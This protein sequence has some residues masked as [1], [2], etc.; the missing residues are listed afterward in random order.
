MAAYAATLLVAGAFI[1]VPL[2]DFFNKWNSYDPGTPNHKTSI[3]DFLED[4]KSIVSYLHTNAT[5]G[6]HTADSIGRVDALL[7]PLPVLTHDP[8]TFGFGLGIG[9]VSSSSLGPQ[10][11]GRYQA[12][13]GDF[14]EVTSMTGFMLELGTFGVLLILLLHWMIF[15]DSV[16]VMR[17]DESMFGTL[18]LAWVAICPLIFAGLFYIMIHTSS[19]V[20]YIF[21]FFSGVIAARRKRLFFAPRHAVQS[22]TQPAPIAARGSHAS[23]P[24]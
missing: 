14:S 15:R 16:T 4:P 17:A 6:M 1:F 24:M 23:S 3:E 5:V 19:V 11:S 8:V 20:S 2:Y 10:F 21:W 13:Y 7:V 18:A 12:T 22:A 9:N